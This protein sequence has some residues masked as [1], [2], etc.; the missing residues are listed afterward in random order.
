MA[1]SLFRDSLQLWFGFSTTV[2][3][4]GLFIVEMDRLWRLHL[5]QSDVVLREFATIE[6]IPTFKTPVRSIGNRFCKQWQFC[7]EHHLRFGKHSPNHLWNIHTVIIMTARMSWYHDFA[8]FSCG[9]YISGVLRTIIIL[10]TVV[11]DQILTLTIDQF[12][13]TILSSRYTIPWRSDCKNN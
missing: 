1:V 8:Y 2:P 6:T 5:M 9:S 12:S 7:F 10:V 3:P 4:L 11:A 13:Y